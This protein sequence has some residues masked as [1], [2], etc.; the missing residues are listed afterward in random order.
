[1]FFHY[2]KD[3]LVV[4]IISKAGLRPIIEIYPYNKKAPIQGEA[5]SIAE[6]VDLARA[7]VGAEISDAIRKEMF[8]LTGPLDAD[9]EDDG[10]FNLE[11][12][13]LKINGNPN[14]IF[15]NQ[16]DALHAVVNRLRYKDFSGRSTIAEVLDE[17]GRKLP[18][19]IFVT[20]EG[21]ARIIQVSKDSETNDV[22]GRWGAVEVPTDETTFNVEMPFN[23]NFVLDSKAVKGNGV[24]E[25]ASQIANL[26][27]R[28]CW[29]D[30]RR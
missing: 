27:H 14:E 3:S 25:V 22:T 7:G 8:P 1:M 10:D 24:E 28:I 6:I 19:I 17:N 4:A 2:C 23:W 15:E 29:G 18:S 13:L 12:E 26:A 21:G 20:L 16:L 11:E 30:L 9:S 5:A